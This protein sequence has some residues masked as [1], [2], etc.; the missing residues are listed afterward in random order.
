MQEGYTTQDINAS[1]FTDRIKDMMSLY[2]REVNASELVQR[3]LCEFYP[4]EKYEEWFK[5]LPKKIQDELTA[6]WGKPS[7]SNM[8]VT[9]QGKQYFAIPRMKVDNFIIL[10]QGSRAEDKND[11]KGSY[12]DMATPI[13]HGYLS[14]YLYVKE[15]FGVDAIVHMGTHGS[16]E[17][18]KGKDRGLSVYDSP[19]LAVGDIPVIYPYIVDDGKGEF[20]QLPFTANNQILKVVGY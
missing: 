18:L 9:R 17:W 3:D 11:E 19:N 12:H 7:T 20:Y 16:Q 4:L 15:V 8:L 1:F 10:P 14:V 13:S 5:T 6:V 2:Y